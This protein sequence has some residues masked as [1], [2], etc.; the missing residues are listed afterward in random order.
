ML[1][2]EWTDVKLESPIAVPSDESSILKKL[3]G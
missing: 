1:I 3:K 2:K